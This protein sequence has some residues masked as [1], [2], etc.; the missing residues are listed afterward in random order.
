MK[1]LPLPEIGQS[2]YFLITT[3]NRIIMGNNITE[4]VLDRLVEVELKEVRED[5]LSVR[6][7]S[8]RHD[9]K[10]TSL[11]HYFNNELCDIYSDIDIVVGYD[12]KVRDISDFDFIKDRWE[13]KRPDILRNYSQDINP[14]VDGTSLLLKDKEKFINSLFGGYSFWRFFFQ[15]WYRR[16]YKETENEKILLKNYF[17]DI[18][19]PLDVKSSILS[20]QDDDS[21][22]WKIK[23]TASLDSKGFD[24][25]GFARMLKNL[26]KV[27]NIDASLALDFEENYTF[28]KNGTLSEAELF[29]NTSVSNW[30]I[31][32]TGHKLI[33]VSK[34][35]LEKLKE[36]EDMAETLENA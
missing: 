26:T 34:T 8:H 22:V 3:A 35:G 16:E 20:R 33:Q 7:C 9:V 1:V 19:L 13:K 15:P 2:A 6:F 27:Y 4:Y 12:G 29:L 31:V 18:S 5:A 24:R 21:I 17:G 11:V 10:G 28:I 36:A 30:Y 25:K 14:L 32:L 23:N